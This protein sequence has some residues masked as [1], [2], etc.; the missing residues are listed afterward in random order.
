MLK[1]WKSSFFIGDQRK[2]HWKQDILD[3]SRTAYSNISAL[4]EL[5]RAFHNK[6][7]RVLV[8]PQQDVNV[9]ATDSND[10]IV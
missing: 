6:G 3:P 9:T 4:T 10:V 5:S 7:Y 2:D 8:P 1:I